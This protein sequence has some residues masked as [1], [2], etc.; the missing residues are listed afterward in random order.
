MKGQIHSSNQDLLAWKIDI[1]LISQRKHFVCTSVCIVW[2]SVTLDSDVLGGQEKNNTNEMKIVGRKNRSNYL[3]ILPYAREDI[4]G[5]DTHQARI[6][7]NI[8]LKI[9]KAKKLK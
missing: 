3:Y 1:F 5:R 8:S 9:R 7:Q 4:F 6:G 2:Y